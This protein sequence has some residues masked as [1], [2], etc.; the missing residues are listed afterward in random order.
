MKTSGSKLL[1]IKMAQILFYLSAIIWS[2]LGFISLGNLAR[3]DPALM[4]VFALVALL[5]FGNAGAMLLAGRRLARR[6]KWALLFALAV[7]SLNLLLTFI[8][9]FGIIDFI[10]AMLDMFIVAILVANWETFFASTEPPAGER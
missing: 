1:S 7:L 9:Q 10:T 4:A 2:L 3:Q 8:D 5:M 6:N